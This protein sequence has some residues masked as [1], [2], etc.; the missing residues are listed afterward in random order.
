MSILL[1]V[2]GF[3]QHYLSLETLIVTQNE[4]TLLIISS[5][6]GHEHPVCVYNQHVSSGNNVRRNFSTDVPLWE[7]ENSRIRTCK[8]EITPKL[9]WNTFM[10]ETHVK[11]I[12][13]EDSHLP[14][15]TKHHSYW[16][17]LSK[18]IQI[19]FLKSLGWSMWSFS[20]DIFH[21]LTDT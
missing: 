1:K 18:Y 11:Q 20:L 10:N 2:D 3:Q 16:F 5:G 7:K 17:K 8:K 13:S 15:G 14:V 12:L 6:F 4:S 19:L 21:L 9:R